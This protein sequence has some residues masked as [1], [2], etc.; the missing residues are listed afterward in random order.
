MKRKSVRILLGIFL[1]L[2]GFILPI[3]ANEESNYFVRAELPENQINQNKSYF[4]LL[5]KPGTKQ[6]LV[7][8]VFNTSDESIDV[9][10]K[11]TNA[12]TNT[13]GT[14]MYTTEGIEDSS[15][16]I[17]IED[18]AQLK[19]DSL[20][21]EAQSSSIFEIELALPDKKFR[22][23]LLGG[24]VIEADTATKS[25]ADNE[26]NS[27]QIENKLT[28]V[29]GLKLQEDLD[30]VVVPNI[31]YLGTDVLLHD[32]STA[33][34]IRLQNS[35]AII[36]KGVQ[37]NA[38]IYRKG[39]KTVLYEYHNAAV[40]IAPNSAFDVAVVWGNEKLQEGTYRLKL[41]VQYKDYDWEWDEEFEIEFEKAAAVNQEAINIK[42]K[43]P[44]WIYF[45]IGTLLVIVLFVTAFS[46]GR[47]SK[48][49]G[50]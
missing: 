2:V 27:I 12:A 24:I 21:I 10:A 26:Q 47:V 31:N 39:S 46:L 3:H 40:E 42:V 30:T 14:I 37:V 50:H 18:I 44:N 17:S 7:V 45:F 23:V 29:I 35:E 16:V 34:G 9:K 11:I 28:Y 22:G 41:R 8:R 36:M 48:K 20:T 4:D 15:M 6:I 38:E 25:K 43:V 13:N 33:V 5:V 1:V 49:S 32:I 19:T